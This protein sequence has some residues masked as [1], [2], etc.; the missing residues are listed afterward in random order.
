M[1]DA[2][3]ITDYLDG[4]NRAFNTLVHRWQP[5]VHNFI[6][7][8][9]GSDSDVGDISQNVFLRVWQNLGVLKDRDRFSSWIFQ[10]AVNQC[11]DHIRSVSRAREHFPLADSEE[12]VETR[13][14]LG[15]AYSP[16]RADSGEDWRRILN[17]VLQTLPE[18]QRLVIVLKEYHGL[19]FNEIAH[20]LQENE[21]T[22]KARLYSGLKNVRRRLEHRG[23][24]KEDMIHEM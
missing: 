6:C 17:S 20:I 19:R 16:D 21:N 12:P 2:Q 7:R 14:A 23:I 5:S 18:D 15:G 22:L 9:M 8:F 24:R 13:A 1:T 3:L 10:I 4:D 11:R